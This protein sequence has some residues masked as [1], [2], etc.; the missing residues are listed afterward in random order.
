[1]SDD[2]SAMVAA[3]DYRGERG[4]VV[5]AKGKMLILSL[6]GAEALAVAIL[7]ILSELDIRDARPSDA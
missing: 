1:M 5:K 4:I 2:N 7:E 3:C 6:P